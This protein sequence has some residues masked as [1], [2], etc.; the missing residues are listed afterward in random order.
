MNDCF[1][2]CINLEYADI[3]NLDLENNKGFM[4]LFKDNKKLKEIKF[5]IKPFSEIY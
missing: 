4:N 1:S 2:G 3:S 5:P